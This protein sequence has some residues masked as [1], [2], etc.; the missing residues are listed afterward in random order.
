MRTVRLTGPYMHNGGMKNLKEVV[1]IYNRGGNLA[2]PEQDA[3]IQPLGLTDEQTLGLVNL[4]KALTDARV[5]QERAPHGSSAV[6]SASSAHAALC[7][8]SSTT[9]K[10]QLPHWFWLQG[11]RF[12]A[13]PLRQSV[14]DTH[15]GAPQS[16][17]QPDHEPDE[18][19]QRDQKDQRMIEG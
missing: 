2:N 12:P 6:E 16:R 15:D 18:E 17:Q 14:K 8:C 11:F 13:E 7:I 19:R 9:R 1:A 10:R 4:L 3:D 5:R